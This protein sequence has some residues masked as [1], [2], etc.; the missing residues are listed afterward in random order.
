M[1]PINDFC[2]QQ[3]W[4]IS[5]SDGTPQINCLDHIFPYSCKLIRNLR[6]TLSAKGNLCCD[7]CAVA[8]KVVVLHEI[9]R[10]W[11]QMGVAGQWEVSSPLHNG[12][13]ASQNR[14]YGLR[15]PNSRIE[16]LLSRV[17]QVAVQAAAQAQHAQMAVDTNAQLVGAH[18]GTL[19]DQVH[20][21]D[22]H[23]IQRIPSQAAVR[24]YILWQRL[25]IVVFR[26]NRGFSVRWLEGAEGS[27]NW[28]R[29]AAAERNRNSN[30]LT[31]LSKEVVICNANAVVFSLYF[32]RLCFEVILSDAHNTV[33]W[34]S[35]FNSLRF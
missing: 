11:Q 28:Q 10:Q 33:F 31:N 29:K 1:V 20:L 7:G 13:Y 8:S 23:R 21:T 25:H 30:S 5:V 35:S 4:F 32:C 26:N 16:V 24:L 9:F 12:S 17:R 2:K 15:E 27:V 18:A 19:S 34:L 22:T 14:S 6:F 3:C